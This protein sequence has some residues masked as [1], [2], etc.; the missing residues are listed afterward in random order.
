MALLRVLTI[1]ALVL[2]VAN[3]ARAGDRA[4]F[5][6]SFTVT[7]KASAD[8]ALHLFDPVGEAAWAKG[9]DPSFVREAD[10]ATLAEG[11]VFTT[12]GA[13]GTQ[14]VWVL[15]RYDRQA[16]EIAY[17]VYKP[18]GV[19]VAIRIALHDTTPR[20]SAALVRYDLVATTDAGDRFVHDYAGS[21]PH[22]GP[23]WQA[24]LDA[25]PAR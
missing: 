11:T 25:V 13:A 2:S 12:P 16:H 3:A 8:T 1:V 23:H 7:L 24:A 21:F 14:T 15:Q 6:G 9:W 10:R 22:M 17:T 18:D 4:A 19:V 20:G 5:S